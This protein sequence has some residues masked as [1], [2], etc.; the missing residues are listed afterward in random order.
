MLMAGQVWGQT[1]DDDVCSPDNICEL[2]IRVA[3]GFESRLQ[4][5]AYPFM[6]VFIKGGNLAPRGGMSF[7]IEAMMITSSGQK[8]LQPDDVP[9]I[10]QGQ[11]HIAQGIGTLTSDGVASTCN[12]LVVILHPIASGN[13][14]I[15]RIAP[16]GG[17]IAAVYAD[18]N[19]GV[20]SPSCRWTVRD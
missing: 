13:T 10:P 11:S 15:Y 14:Q 3:P 6:E 7:G 17:F 12:K 2:G 8:I 20:Q 1:P 19:G 16:N 4:E 18:A 9:F 5:G